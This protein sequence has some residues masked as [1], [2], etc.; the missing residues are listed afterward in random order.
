MKDTIS[1]RIP[2]YFGY[3]DAPEPQSHI[4]SAKHRM[5]KQ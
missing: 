5:E 2:L 3:E 1:W 4:Q